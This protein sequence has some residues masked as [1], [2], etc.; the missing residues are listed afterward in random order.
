MRNAPPLSCP[1]WHHKRLYSL[2]GLVMLSLGL[3]GMLAHL[4]RPQIKGWYQTLA[5]PIFVP[6][7]VVFALVWSG[8]FGLMAISFWHYIAPDH[9]QQPEYRRQ[10]RLGLLVFCV[11]YLVCCLWPVGFFGLESTFLGM[12]G[13]WILWPLVALSMNIMGRVDVFA[14]RLLWPYLVWVT[15]AVVMSTGVH[16]LN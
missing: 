3:N 10:Y 14:A 11:Q 15:L 16:V 1:C 6:P 5:K 7:D 12:I 2:I 13:T 4:L 9:R 8:L